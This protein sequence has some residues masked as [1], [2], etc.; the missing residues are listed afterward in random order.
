MTEV[1]A[2][3]LIVGAGPAGIAAACA[4]SESG[5]RVLVVDD[6][7][8]TGGQIWRGDAK[9]QEH[10]ARGWLARLERSGAA[11]FCG[12]RAL[13]AAGANAII[14]EKNEEPLRIRFAK[15][16]LAT[17][18]RELWLPFPGWTLAGV[19]GAGGLQALVQGGA[20]IEGRRVVV[21][22]S[23]PLLLAVAAHLRDR[24][25]HIAAV[26]EQATLGSLLRFAAGL[27]PA[28]LLQALQLRSHLRGVPLLYSAWPLAAEGNG[29][30]RAVHLQT[31]EG[32]LRV[33]CDYL[34]C[35]FGLV[36][37]TELAQL[38]GCKL[39][40][41]CELRGDFVAVDDRQQTSVANVLC[42]GE[43]T[44]IGGVEASLFE[45]EVAGYTA[46]G[47][48][49]PARHLAARRRRLDLF[50]ARLGAAFS[51]RDE[52]R[53]ICLPDT[54]VCRC[55]DAPY[56]QI[57]RH[58]D[59]RS[60]KLHTRCGMGPCQGRVCGA[61]LSFLK[62]WHDAGRQVRP[63]LFPASVETLASL[64]P[65]PEGRNVYSRMS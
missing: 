8:E 34:A 58:S 1:S 13:A 35:G 48:M 20:P 22:G 28:K 31:P 21:A 23:G 41:G 52:L 56:E 10:I 19:A 5:A 32:R 12:T 38:L 63:P 60:A 37:N 17:G 62:G 46:A 54:I 11:I 15:L 42:A 50:S 65:M 27:A 29:R 57:C 2:E 64:N 47:A 51:L 39:R 4:A 3:V 6:N 36:P 43:P 53:G 14:A 7:P 55:E 26:A 24:G 49:H 25:A 61:A 18:A 30:V 45:G 16:I 9:R 44:G 40:G 33:D 59:W